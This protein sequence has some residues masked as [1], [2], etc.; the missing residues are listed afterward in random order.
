[1]DEPVHP[2]QR[3]AKSATGWGG[4]FFPVELPSHCYNTTLVSNVHD[5]Q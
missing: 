5:I 2:V 1:M 4:C 3:H